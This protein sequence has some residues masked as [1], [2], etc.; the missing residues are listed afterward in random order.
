MTSLWHYDFVHQALLAGA[1]TAV[2]A[3]TIG[4]FVT[5]RNMS[6]AVHGLAEVGFT[7]AAGAIFLGAPPEAGLLTA[8]FLA[9]AAFGA[10]GVRLRERDVAIGSVL[11]FAIGLGVLFLS[12]YTKY[13]TEAFTILFGSVLAVSHADVVRSAAVGTAA[14]AGL[15]VIARP[16]RFASI[17]PEVAEARGVPVRTLSTVFLVI[18]ALAVAV[19][20]QVVGVLLILTLVITPSGAAQRLTLHPARI[21]LYSVGIALG[22][23]LG[24]IALAVSTSLPT[25]FFVSAL[26]LGAY[27]AARW[28]NPVRWAGRGTAA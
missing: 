16:L 27:L 1:I 25:S 21:L 3:G 14:L 19:T 2:V 22:A 24:G 18:L 17:D 10:L 20:I 26:S 28:L 9:A 13:A 5:L 7:G 12:L 15:A 6:F 23:T 8:C 4:P 11:A